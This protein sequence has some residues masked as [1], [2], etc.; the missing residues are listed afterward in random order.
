MAAI[1][2]FNYNDFK[3]LHTGDLFIN[4]WSYSY[5]LEKV[6]KRNC[7]FCNI[8][9]QYCCDILK[10]RWD[11]EWGNYDHVMDKIFK[12]DTDKFIDVAQYSSA[13]KHFITQDLKC[14][15]KGNF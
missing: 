9:R 10:K 15:E 14:I 11:P 8:Y 1:Q 12:N 2:K 7:R 3:I 5:N 6:C 13:E 4:I